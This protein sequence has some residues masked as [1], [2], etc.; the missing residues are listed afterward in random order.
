MQ[1][2]EGAE[3]QQWLRQWEANA[4]KNIEETKLTRSVVMVYLI[5]GRGQNLI[6]A[7]QL[8]NIII[9]AM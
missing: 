2:G 3:I 8:S 9:L 7:I 5:H 1:R 4:F 6:G